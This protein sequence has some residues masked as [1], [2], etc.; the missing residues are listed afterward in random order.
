MVSLTNNTI[1]KYV[2]FFH[3]TECTSISQLLWNLYTFLIAI[4]KWFPICIMN[5]ILPEW[6]FSLWSIKSQLSTENY[7]FNRNI[8]VIW[9]GLSSRY[10]K[11]IF[12]HSFHSGSVYHFR[13]VLKRRFSY[14]MRDVFCKTMHHCVVTCS[15]DV[16]VCASIFHLKFSIESTHGWLSLCASVHGFQPSFFGYH[17]S[18]MCKHL[19]ALSRSKFFCINSSA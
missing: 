14:M 10:H 9:I 4:D 11:N 5:S 19:M 13:I 18:V 1:M 8:L 3:F 12:F 7:R 15:C 2:Q 16:N 6:N 17:H